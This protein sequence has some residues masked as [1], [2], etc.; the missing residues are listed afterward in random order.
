[1]HQGNLDK[2]K[3]VYRINAVYKVT[4]CQFTGCME[5]VSV[6]YPLVVLDCPPAFF[7]LSREASTP[8]TAPRTSTTTALLVKLCVEEF[9]KSHRWQC[10]YE[11]SAASNTASVVASSAATSRTRGVTL[12]A[13]YRFHRTMRA[14]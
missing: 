12:S 2:V 10:N 11:A 1:M 8:A 4:Q 7:P 3:G 13:W 6:R 9:A 14:M 5:R